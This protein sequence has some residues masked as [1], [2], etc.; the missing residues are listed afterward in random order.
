MA[1]GHG[2]HSGG[3]VDFRD[4]R[5]AQSVGF[6]APHGKGEGIMAFIR[7]LIWR[8]RQQIFLQIMLAIQL[9]FVLAA[10]FMTVSSVQEYSLGVRLMDRVQGYEHAWYWSLEDEV[11]QAEQQAMDSGL[12]EGI[13]QLNT[14][15]FVTDKGGYDLQIYNPAMADHIRFSMN[16]GEWIGTAQPQ[17]A[18]GIVVD[19]KMARDYPVGS[20]VEGHFERWDAQN[21]QMVSV[22]FTMEVVGVVGLDGYIFDFYRGGD[23]VRAEDF[24]TPL[25]GY[26]IIDERDFSIDWEQNAPGNR[27]IFPKAGVD[28][29]A[30]RQL[31]Q[32]LRT[33]GTLIDMKGIKENASAHFRFQIGY[34]M[35]SNAALALLGL[36]GLI[37]SMML[38]GMIFERENGIY[39]VCGAPPQWILAIEVVRYAFICLL[40][41]AAGYY[42]YEMS[43]LWNGYINERTLP[44]ALGLELALILLAA[45]AAAGIR[46]KV[47]LNARIGGF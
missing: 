38:S 26:A 46:P 20:L 9:F 6:E 22:P 28:G 5:T 3:H 33:R 2:G 42:H 45:L 29:A 31:M 34:W 25:E 16:R 37:G 4:K 14:D 23:A 8:M 44:I 12:I 40:V 35:P 47:R 43:G 32:T 24:F 30:L 17:R 27:M 15:Y 41:A 13:G 39:A 36:L 21:Q 1:D 7:T 18:P 11:A 10:C 19:E